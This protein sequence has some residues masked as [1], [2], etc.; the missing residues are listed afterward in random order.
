MPMSRATPTAIH[1]RLDDGAHGFDGRGVAACLGRCRRLGS[2]LDGR[3]RSGLR[4]GVRRGCLRWL[5]VRLAG[6]LG[7]LLRSRGRRILGEDRGGDHDHAG[8]QHCGLEHDDAAEEGSPRDE[9]AASRE[10]LPVERVVRHRDTSIA[11]GPIGRDPPT[12]EV[13]AHGRSAPVGPVALLQARR[14]R[15]PTTAETAP[16]S[17]LAASMTGARPGLSR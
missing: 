3:L 7:L 1:R 6:R 2:G 10:S 13:D 16:Q 9:E 4:R 12:L 5:R 11:G 14:S 17:M 8:Q 15:S